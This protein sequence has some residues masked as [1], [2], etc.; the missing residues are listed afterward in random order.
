MN[1]AVSDCTAQWK[2]ALSDVDTKTKKLTLSVEDVLNRA[3]ADEVTCKRIQTQLST[4]K[5]TLERVT[6]QVQS[7]TVE[8]QRVQ[9]EITN[10]L[11]KMESAWDDAVK[12]RMD[13]SLWMLLPSQSYC[14]TLTPPTPPHAG[15]A[16][17]RARG[18]VRDEGDDRDDV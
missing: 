10:K 1:S 9:S 11:V 8:A 4:T 6:L 15:R 7:V 3:D 5:T 18:G 12:V 13:L 2:Q 17:G 16:G 14:Y